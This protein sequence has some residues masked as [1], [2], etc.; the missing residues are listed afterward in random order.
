MSSSLVGN[1]TLDETNMTPAMHVAQFCFNH[2]Q[3]YRLHWTP[4][5][6]SPITI[7]NSSDLDSSMQIECC[8]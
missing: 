7:V 1:N 4:L 5:T 2:S 3:N 8:C 6:C